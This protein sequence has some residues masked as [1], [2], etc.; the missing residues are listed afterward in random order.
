[1]AQPINTHD[2]NDMVGIREDLRDVVYNIDPDETPA[3]SGLKKVKAKNTFHEWQTDTLRSSADNINIEGDDIVPAAITPT[4]R[5][6][7]YTQ[8]FV[9]A[10]TVTD[11]DQAL[12][13]A[14]R[15]KEMAYQIRK[16]TRELKL[17]IERAIFLNNARV[18]G[19]ST[20]GREFAGMQT[21]M[22]SNTSGGSGASDATGDG[23]D[24]R[25]AGTARALT[26]T[27][28]DTVMQSCWDNSGSMTRNA[29]LSSGQMNVCLGFTGNNNQRATVKAAE[30]VV[31]NAVDVYITPWGAV[32]F[33][34]SR[35]CPTSEVFIIDPK[36]WSIAELRTLRNFPLAKTG[37]SE[38]RG[39]DCELTLCAHNEASSGLI[40]DLS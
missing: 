35:E 8:I 37:T 11:T 24:A 15:A 9:E 33:M 31:I 36:M 13:K 20:T 18:A 1:M 4:T 29:Y 32:N 14:G 30:N 2:S 19:S 38:K 7:D 5:L 26:Q 22:T 23:T 34:M 40:A 3:L 17:D 10:A 25:T 12:D 27:I 6:G 16:K 39:M 28:F 21:W